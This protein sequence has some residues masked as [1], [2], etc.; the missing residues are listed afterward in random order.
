MRMVRYFA[1]AAPGTGSTPTLGLEPAL[2]CSVREFS[3]RY[4]AAGR[5]VRRG[6]PLVSFPICSAHARYCVVQEA[7]TTA[8]STRLQLQIQVRLVRGRTR[9]SV[10]VRDNGVGMSSARQS[11][12]AHGIKERVKE[13]DAEC[14]SSTKPRRRDSLF[15]LPAYSFPRTAAPARRTPLRIVLAGPSPSC[16][17]RA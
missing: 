10:S 17:A 1:M 6:R 14:P 13:H 4:T 7:R 11:P 15:T 2:A 9:S 8:R 16:P 3:R 12:G 5:S